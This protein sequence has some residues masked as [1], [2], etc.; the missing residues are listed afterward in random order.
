[1]TPLTIK[2]I[3]GAVFLLHLIVLADVI[4]LAA[5]FRAHVKKE[6]AKMNLDMGE[7]GGKHLTGRT[8]L[9]VHATENLH[10]GENVA[11]SQVQ[12]RPHVQSISREEV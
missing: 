5:F 2:L 1:M 4:A 11:A 3:L 9:A 8:P 10:L 12:F 7:S 6:D